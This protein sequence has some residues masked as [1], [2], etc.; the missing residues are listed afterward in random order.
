MLPYTSAE[1]FGR[2][3]T[4]DLTRASQPHASSSPMLES[5]CARKPPVTG[6]CRAYSASIV[7]RCQRV[8]PNDVWSSRI[9]NSAPAS[10]S[11]EISGR[12]FGLPR[13]LGTNPL[14]V[15]DV[16]AVYVVNLS[17]APG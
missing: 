11:V 7:L 3:T 8:K 5:C 10:I 9:A 16:S 2:L 13:L 6:Y 14:P 4:N 1:G 15:G 12:R 17:N